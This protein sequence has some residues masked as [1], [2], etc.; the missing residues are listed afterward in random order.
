MIPKKNVKTFKQ[1]SLSQPKQLLDWI[2]SATN[3]HCNKLF[4]LKLPKV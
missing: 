3:T 2:S 4:S 1:T